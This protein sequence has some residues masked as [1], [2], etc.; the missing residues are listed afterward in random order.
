[1][2]NRLRPPGF[3][4]SSPPSVAADCGAPSRP[5]GLGDGARLFRARSLHADAQR[6]YNAAAD[7]DEALRQGAA[8]PSDRLGG[9]GEAKD[10]K[11]RTGWLGRP[12]G[13]VEHSLLT[14]QA[15]A[16]YEAGVVPVR[17]VAR[18]CGVSLRT[19][20]HHVHK[21]G[22]RR[23]RSSVPRDAAKSE[24]QKRRYRDLKA[25]QPATPRGLKARDPAG[26][27]RALA[28][29]DRAAALSGAA[30]S[31]ALAR[32]D[33]EAKARI[34]SILT[35]ALR[36]LTLARDGVAP[37]RVRGKDRVKRKRREYKWRPLTGWH[38]LD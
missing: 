36:D 21:Q 37:R 4:A 28:L 16:L 26:H 24:R 22:W 9:E 11:P 20:Y 17:A 15:R 35:R 29:A 38:A 23:R 19:L 10:N 32:Q 6:R 5:Y 25:L 27:T 3:G 14:H 2:T 18:L 12:P 34:L 33:A 8:S 31:R 30:L 7:G 1:M 13:E